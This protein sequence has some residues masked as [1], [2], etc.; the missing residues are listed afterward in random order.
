MSG[1]TQRTLFE[2]SPSNEEDL[3]FY[4]LPLSR[5]KQDLFRAEAIQSGSAIDFTTAVFCARTL[6]FRVSTEKRGEKYFTWP[7]D[8]EAQQII[9][10][11]IPSD[12]ILEIG[13]VIMGYHKEPEEDG[14]K[15]RARVLQDLSGGSNDPFEV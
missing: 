3:A 14:I 11:Q 8:L 7:E 4:Y 2:V 12:T 1:W 5:E 13:S 6:L 9:L 15:F 10:N